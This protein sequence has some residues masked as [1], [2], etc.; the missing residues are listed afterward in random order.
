MSAH[1]FLHQQVIKKLIASKGNT[2][3]KFVEDE[4][5]IGMLEDKIYFELSEKP[6]RIVRFTSQAPDITRVCKF[7]SLSRLLE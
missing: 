7:Y 1:Y 6:I 5:Y 3:V 2:M 4:N